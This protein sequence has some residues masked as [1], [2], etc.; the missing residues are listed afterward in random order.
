MA[1]VGSGGSELTGL[2]AFRERFTMHL[3]SNEN[4][5]CVFGTGITVNMTGC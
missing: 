5:G 4:H 3:L 1:I 2:A